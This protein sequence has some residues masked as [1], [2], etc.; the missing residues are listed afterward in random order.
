MTYRQWAVMVPDGAQWT[1]YLIDEDRRYCMDVA[2]EL[3]DGGHEAGIM[4]VL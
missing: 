4:E 3:R 2:Q 1:V